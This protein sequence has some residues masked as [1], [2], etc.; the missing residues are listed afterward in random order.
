M[1]MENLA[2]SARI[3]ARIIGTQ[4]GL[5]RVCYCGKHQLLYLRK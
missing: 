3:V 5:L 1:G 2:D 4:I